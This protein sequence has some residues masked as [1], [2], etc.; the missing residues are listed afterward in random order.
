MVQSLFARR[1]LLIQTVKGNILETGT[2]V[3][4]VAIWLWYVCM[5]VCI[6]MGWKILCMIVVYRH[7]CMYVCMYVGDHGQRDRRNH[8]T[9]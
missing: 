1:S 2:L 5:Y 6:I 4:V 3:N 9:T 8:G 7:V